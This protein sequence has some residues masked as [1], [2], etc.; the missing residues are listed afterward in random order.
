M[1]HPTRQTATWKKI[2]HKHRI[3]VVV[4][5]I[6]AIILAGIAFRPLLERVKGILSPVKMLSPEEEKKLMSGSSI[7]ENGMMNLSFIIPHGSLVEE[8]NGMV[9][10]TKRT[11]KK[12]PLAIGSSSAS[13]VTVTSFSWPEADKIRQFVDQKEPLRKNIGMK[14]KSHEV[15]PFG[16]FG[17]DIFTYEKG[18]ETATVVYF[19]KRN[20]V[21]RVELGPSQS[22]EKGTYAYSILT[23]MRY[24]DVIIP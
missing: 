12:M 22:P 3:L 13:F 17:G 9:R 4:A 20:T 11:P 16:Y 5:A 15:R 14:V 7:Y 6:L 1:H 24:M 18:R 10:I 2:L 23:G 8:K 19:R 21:Y